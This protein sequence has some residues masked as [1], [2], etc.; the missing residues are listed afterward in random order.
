MPRV[1]W[2]IDT[3]GSSTTMNYLHA[4]GSYNSVVLNRMDF[5][6]QKYRNQTRSRD[7]LWRGYHDYFPPNESQILCHVSPRHYNTPASF[8]AN[9][10]DDRIFAWEVSN[11][12]AASIGT[13][14]I[15]DDMTRMS[16]IYPTN[17][18]LVFLGNDFQWVNNV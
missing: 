11:E 12:T 8:G 7:F 1:G 13:R 4:K 10:H 14:A 18:I 15:I 9:P 16:A 2:Q 5:S 3:F 6:E 17:D